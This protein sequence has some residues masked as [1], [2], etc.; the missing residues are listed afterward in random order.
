MG[1]ELMVTSK[2]GEGSTFRFT[3]KLG[4]A[5]EPASPR[6]RDAPVEESPALAPQAGLRLLIA[7]DSSDNRL[8]L[9]AYLKGG[10]YAI[11]F[12]ED[13][14]QAVNS[15]LSGQFDLILM[16]MEMPVTDGL[17]ATSAIRV[18][19]REQGRTRTAIVSL[20]A[21]ALPNDIEAMRNAGC[22][23]HLSKPISRQKLLTAI[24]RYSSPGVTADS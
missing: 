4:A 18:F 21:N 19:E 15:F 6:D 22:D 17:A 12:A 13:G 2:V 14:K 16:D 3:A 9:Q 23:A 11:T 24:E 10:A 20:T 5:T 7:E 8:L 1:G